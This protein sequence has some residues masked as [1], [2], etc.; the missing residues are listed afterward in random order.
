MK[1]SPWL[2]QADVFLTLGMAFAVWQFLAFPM[3]YFLDIIFILAGI[4]CFSI[5]MWRNEP[6]AAE[7]E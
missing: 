2:R 6:R 4:V 5:G 1:K 7:Y 3:S